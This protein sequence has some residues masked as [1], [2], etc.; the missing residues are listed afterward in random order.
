MKS[1]L[2][3]FYMVVGERELQNQVNME[4]MEYMRLSWN[5]AKC[6]ALFVFLSLLF[7]FLAVH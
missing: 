6:T 3:V 1:K 4:V 2:Q 7:F 5:I